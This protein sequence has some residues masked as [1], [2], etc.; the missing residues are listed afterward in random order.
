MGKILILTVLLVLFAGCSQ[1]SNKPVTVLDT[2]MGKIE[3][4]LRPDIAPVTVENF[5]AL[6]NGTVEWTETKSGKKFKKPFYDGLTFHKLV[7]NKMIH[8][9]DPDGND[10]GGPGFYYE[11]ECYYDG[12][13]ITGKITDLKTARRVLEEIVLPYFK[14]RQLEDRD[15]ELFKIFIE[16]SQKKSPKPIMQHPVEY[17]LEKTKYEKKFVKQGELKTK[18]E[19]G[20]VCM[21]N[22]GTNIN[23][24]RFF[25]VTSKDGLPE[26]DGFYTVFGKVSKGMDVVHSIEGVATDRNMKPLKEITLKESYFR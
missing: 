2:S 3:V 9:G 12:D 21:A 15:D 5:T 10:Q 22:D 23:G 13:P 26:M 8:T 20:S 19:Y 16:C 18:I 25:I 17:Y 14:R 7:K 11:N 1:N 4:V 24:S 6:V